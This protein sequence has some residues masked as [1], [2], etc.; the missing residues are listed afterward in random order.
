[1]GLPTGQKLVKSCS[2]GVQTC[3]THISETAGWIY[4]IRSSMELS[5]PVVVQHQGHMTLT[6]DFQG[7]IFKKLHH[8]NRR[9]DRHGTKSMWIDRES[10][11]FCGFGLWPHPWPWPWIFKVKFWR[12]CISRMWGSID[13]ERK[14]SESIGFWTHYVTL[15]YDLDLGVSRSNFEKAVSQEWQG[16]LTWNKRDVSR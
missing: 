5:R 1:M 14:G 8:R 2:T 3:G 7:Q 11:P 13:M 4:T 12:S 6:L 15:T 10:G 16:R 9:A